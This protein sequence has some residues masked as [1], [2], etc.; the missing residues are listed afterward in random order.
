MH[1]FSEKLSYSGKNN[2]KVYSI[3]TTY[4]LII[5]SRMEANEE[6]QIVGNSAKSYPFTVRQPL[7]KGICFLHLLRHTIKLH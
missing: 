7:I 5:N 4:E 1:E 3:P 6:N 2:I